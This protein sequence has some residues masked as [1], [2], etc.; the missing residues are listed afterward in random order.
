MRRLAVLLIGLV[1]LGAVLLLTTLPANEG[2]EVPGYMEADLVLVGSEQG[3]RVATLAVQEGDRVKPGDPIF[4]LE[5]SEQEAAVDAAQSRLEEAQARLA[6]VKAEAQRPREIEVLEAVLAQAEA[7]RQQSI[8]DLERVQA[9]Y[10]KGWV[11]KAQLDDGVAKHDRNDAAVKEA[12]RRIAAARLPGRSGL[13]DAAAAN[14]EA[15][16][17]GLI[18]AQ[19]N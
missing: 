17:H 3:G 4:T 1:V 16:R 9:L 18:E 19:K 8:T 5:S 12:E 11:S 2:A 6:D 7:M 10:D 14:A 15:A 13:I